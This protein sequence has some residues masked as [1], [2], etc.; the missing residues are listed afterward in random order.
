[1]KTVVIN[2]IKVAD[3]N[4][5]EGLQEIGK[6]IKDKINS[7]ICFCEANILSKTV[8]SKK[9]TG[10]L[11]RAKIVFPDGIIFSM[12]GKVLGIKSLKRVSGPTFMLK[13][14]EYGQKQNWRHFLYGGTEDT[15]NKLEKKLKAQYPDA[16]IVGKYSP[17]FRALS[18]EEEKE[19]KR[20]IESCKPDL[21]WV[22]LGGPKQEFWME[23]HLNK[24]NVSVMLGVGAAFDFHGG[25]RAWAPKIIRKTGT[26]WLFRM[27][28]GGRKTFIRNIKCVSVSMFILVL[29][30]ARRLVEF[31]ELFLCYSANSLVK[32]NF[33]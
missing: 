31:S 19:V 21:L 23:K 16:Q 11:N 17:P 3:T 26:E 9:V 20:M 4:V 1:M 22:G 28:T 24:I 5:Q 25:S 8:A 12:L 15:L 30:M 14:F 29:T 2:K 27:L 33:K 10:V 7:Y 6:L 18:T 32:S 13:S